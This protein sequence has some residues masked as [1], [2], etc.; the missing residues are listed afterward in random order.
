MKN[1]FENFSLKKKLLQ[2]VALV[3]CALISIFVFAKLTSSPDFYKGT[4]AEL[5]EKQGTVMELS[6]ASAAASA[7]ITMIP[8]DVATPIADKLADLS[9]HFLVVLSTIFLEKYLLTITGMVTFTF[10]IP[11]ACGMLILNLLFGWESLRLLAMR[12][13]A[14]GLV[15]VL[16]I[17]ASIRISN[18]IEVTYQASIEQTL[19]T[20]KE[21]TA[22]FE[23]EVE[24]QPELEEQGFWSGV[25]STVTNSV[26]NTISGVTEKAG[27]M[28]NNF[29]EALAVM[30]VTS[31]V[32][33]VLVLLS[34]V[35]FARMILSVDLT[36][37]YGRM[38]QG[39]K[40]VNPSRN[41]E[42]L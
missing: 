11:I 1:F 38:Y 34:F 6:A 40:K 3:L 14:F 9:S 28:V 5:E 20:A 12:L 29:M 10:L 15:I 41:T 26:S 19:E 4:L 13:A 23:E 7:A 37:S 36:I 25:V 42:H 2:V 21:T 39:M 35:W 32:I 27:E 33:P 31:C 17:P 30:L 22:D 24:Q 16:V 8:G 18:I